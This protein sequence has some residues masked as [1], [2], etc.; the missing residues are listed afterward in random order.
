MRHPE[1][2]QLLRYADGE[3]PARKASEIRSHLEACWQCR[4][5]LEELHKTVGECVRYRKDVLQTHLPPPP[6]PWGDIYPRFREIDA[7]LI[8]PSLF[9]RVVQGLQFPMRQVRRWAPAAVTVALIWALFHQLRHTPSVQAAELLRKAVAAAESRPHA[10]RRIQIRTR[11]SRLTRLV[12]SPRQLAAASQL[13]NS[14]ASGADSL[15]S[16]QALF[17]KANYSWEDPLSA[18]SYQAWRDQLSDKR[19]EVSTIGEGPSPERSCY[20]IRTTTA[21]GELIEAA[22]KL[23]VQDLHPFEAKLEFR[24]QEWVEI[25]ELAEVPAAASEANAAAGGVTRVEPKTASKREPIQPPGPS[26]TLGDELRVLAALHQVGAD[27]GD[28]VEV[29]RAGGQIMVAGV[30]IAP[31]RQQQIHDVLSSLPNVVVRFSDPVAATSY[32][33][34][35]GPTDASLSAE[36]L[37]LQARMEQQV[38]GAPYFEELSVQLLDVSE[39]MMSRAYALR[40]LAERFPREVESQLGLQ[41]RQLLRNLHREHGAALAK[42]AAEIERLLNPVL[43]SLGGSAGGSSPSGIH[44]DSWQLAT[45]ALFRAARRVETL[46]AE[47]LAVAPAKTSSSELPSQ[48]L[49]SL[50]QLRASSE[51]CERITA[52]QLGGKDR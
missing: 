18:A 45:E 40:R 39:T 13:S 17:R 50:A 9:G 49:F 34:T 43:V 41:D 11:N 7:S 3:L 21:T 35:P 14:S 48:L 10:A 26:A 6:A 1:D 47:I 29:T 16:L 30:G 28:P 37:R 44:F 15:D 4:T 8:R 23:R 5:E 2:E 42:Q 38:G 52:Q 32:P 51:A 25:T 46:L 24:N 33:E 22:L 12:G 36:G 27:L 20:R 19:D 31:Q